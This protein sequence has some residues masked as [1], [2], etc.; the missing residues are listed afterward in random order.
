[1]SRMSKVSC[2]YGAPMGRHSYG[3]IQNCEARTVRL[4]RINL[5]SG[6]YDNGGAYWGI[7]APIYCATDDADYF[8]TA[9][10][11]NRGEAARLLNIEPYQLK[12]GN[13]V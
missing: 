7:G 6:G 11:L 4:F 13:H 9:R 1:M 10:A 2:K 5:D 12:R 8:A 3:L